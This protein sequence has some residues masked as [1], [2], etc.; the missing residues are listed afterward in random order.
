MGSLPFE[1]LI[2]QNNRC[3]G[4]VSE[5]LWHAFQILTKQ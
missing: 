2:T 4:L 3:L 1:I 5:S